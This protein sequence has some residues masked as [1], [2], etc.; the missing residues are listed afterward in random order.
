MVVMRDVEANR[1]FVI[2]DC[3]LTYSLENYHHSLVYRWQMR[4]PIRLMNLAWSKGG[5]TSAHLL[6]NL[7]LP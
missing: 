5:K 7:L 2:K 6:R 3:E 4:I 1:E